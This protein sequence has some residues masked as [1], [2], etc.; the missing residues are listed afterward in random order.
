[1]AGTGPPIISTDIRYCNAIQA[2]IGRNAAARGVSGC[3][4]ARYDA[5]PMK[6]LGLETSCDETGVAIYDTGRG[7][8]AHALHSQV[9]LHAVYGGVVPEIASRDH[10]RRLLPMIR[11]LLDEAGVSRPDAIAYTAG[12]GLV[13]ALMVG[14]GLAN[15]LGI[16]WD[17]PV[18]AVHHMEGH[19]L[20]PM[21]EEDKPEFPF[22]A[23]LVSGGHTM[24]VSVA[25]L[26]AYTVL[27]STLDDAVG[28]A[29]D[30]TAKLLGLGYPGGPALSRLAEDGTD[31]AFDFPRPMLNRPGFDFSFSG[32]KT[33]V[34]LQVRKS[35]AAGDFDSVR[36]NIAA[37]FQKAAVDTLVGRTLRAAKDQNASSVVVAGGVGANSCLRAEL[38]RR[39]QGRVYYP[40]A[41]F[42]TD[43]GAMI[44][45]A[46]AMRLADAA[47][48]GTI[49]ARAR[50]DLDSLSP[51]QTGQQ[52][53]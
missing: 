34:M 42:C 45:F 44:A 36:A 47:T 38:R 9:D 18:I 31:T 20:A 53:T 32:L 28:E 6:V 49:Q 16:A 13:G 22:L 4:A 19:L 24:L 23:L 3:A 50:W 5:A 2:K 11:A 51:P 12:P 21:L 26:G 41:E 40:R 43:N 17:C 52:V 29:F 37:S 39:F 25:G 1:M 48:P 27:G 33:A 46:G 15:G 7:L 35:Q 14:A 8:V 10:I 30:K